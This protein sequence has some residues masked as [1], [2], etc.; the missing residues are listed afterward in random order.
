MLPQLLKEK[1][2]YETVMVGK[3]HLGMVSEAYLPQSRGFDRFFGYYNGVQDYWGHFNDEAFGVW[4]ASLHENDTPVYSSTGTYSSELFL[5]AAKGYISDFARNASGA[6]TPAELRT[7]SASASAT[8]R[9]HSAAN[10]ASAARGWS[11]RTTRPLFMYFAL[12]SI[13]SANNKHLQAAQHRQSGRRGGATAGHQ[14]LVRLHLKAWGYPMH[15]GGEAHRLRSHREA[16]TL[17]QSH[18]QVA[19]FA[20]FDHPGAAGGARRV[21]RHRAH[22]LRPVRPPRRGARPGRRAAVRG[23]QGAPADGRRDDHGPR[24]RGGRAARRARGLRPVERHAARLHDRQ[25]RTVRRHTLL[26]CRSS[27]PTRPPTHPPTHQS[28]ISPACSTR[29]RACVPSCA[30]PASLASRRPSPR[31]AAGSTASTPTRRRTGPCAAA[32]PTTSR[33]ACAAS[34]SCTAPASAI[35]PARRRRENGRLGVGEEGVAGQ[36]GPL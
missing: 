12:Q 6:A 27:R 33:A 13:H 18:A 7:A 25:R 26:S 22:P 29:M 9:S 31:D 20:A 24:R 1:F 36:R 30:H 32:R 16:A 23:A 2:G 15:S 14:R 8:S 10:A 19:I 35:S 28:T 5:S 17:A 21:R 11:H 4:G 34:A 3:W